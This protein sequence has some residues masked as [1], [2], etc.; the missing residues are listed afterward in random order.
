MISSIAIANNIFLSQVR[1]SGASG[2]QESVFT[3]LKA[4]KHKCVDSFIKENFD[5]D[6]QSN[7][8]IFNAKVIC[9]GDPQHTSNLDEALNSELLRLIAAIG[10]IVLVE[11]VPFLEFAG[12]KDFME[13]GSITAG[14]MVI[15]WDD[16]RLNRRCMEISRDIL[17][18]ASNTGKG[19][20][21]KLFAELDEAVKGRNRCMLS[22]INTISAPRRIIVLAGKG[23]F[24]HDKSLIDGIKRSKDSVIILSPKTLS[25][26][27]QKTVRKYFRSNYRDNNNTILTIERPGRPDVKIWCGFF[28]NGARVGKG[29]SVYL[30]PGTLSAANLAHFGL[31]EMTPYK[32]KHID[33]YIESSPAAF[34]GTILPY[35]GKF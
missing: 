11:G 29:G 9:L 33:S 12:K 7:S 14:I 15:G 19:D 32:V 31:K 6:P 25:L 30:R 27:T 13:T 22:T 1:A 34:P 16:P 2:T 28:D 21:G 18:T 4:A 17:D 10:D 24:T 35:G 8:D 3:L 20:T 23:H 26:D 5:V